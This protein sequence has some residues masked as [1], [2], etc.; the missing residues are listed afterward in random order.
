MERFDG[1]KSL[2]EYVIQEY[3]HRACPERNNILK[4]LFKVPGTTKEE[5]DAAATLEAE[6]RG[7]EK[8]TIKA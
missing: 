2:V 4:P 3:L 7:V 1:I 8:L 6:S 5:A